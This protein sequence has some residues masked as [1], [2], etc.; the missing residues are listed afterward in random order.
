MKRGESVTG[1]KVD[2]RTSKIKKE[3][4]PR[5]TLWTLSSSQCYSFP[6]FSSDFLKQVL[7]M[8]TIFGVNL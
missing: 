6:D 2:K 5:T 1:V 7:K 3:F 8:G 4:A